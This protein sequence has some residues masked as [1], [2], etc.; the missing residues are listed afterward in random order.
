M[1]TWVSSAPTCGVLGFDADYD[2]GRSDE[3]LVALAEGDQRI[4]LTRD[5]GLLKR[6]SVMHGYC[7]RSTVPSEQLLEVVGRFDLLDSIRLS[8]RCVRCNGFLSQVAKSD[9]LERLPERTI[10]YYD[11]YWMCESCGQPYWRGSHYR[12]QLRLLALVQGEVAK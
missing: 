7:I 12:N 6:A 8:H 9:L 11:Q 2:N 10:L 5:R 4:L 3:E 1:F